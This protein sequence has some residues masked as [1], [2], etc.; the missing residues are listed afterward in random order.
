MTELE[1]HRITEVK[2]MRVRSRYPRTIT[3]N[4][5][6][7]V[8]GDGPNSQIRVI[9]TDGGASGW[10]IS[11]TPDEKTPD[12]VG[13]LVSELF[14]PKIG[15]IAEEAVWLDFPLHDL[16]GVILDKPVYQ[17]LGVKGDTA[18]P[19]YDGAI[20]MDDLIPEYAPRGIKAIIENC[21]NDYSMGYRA[22]K[23]KIGRGHKWM[24]FEEGLKRDIEVTRAVRENFSDCQILVDANDGYD[25]DGFLRY[26]DAVADC[27][28]FWI[29]EPFRENRDDLSRLRE[30]L[31][32][33]S[34]KTLVADG[35]SGPDV[36]FL[37]EL[38]REKLVDVL[39]MDIAG[40]GFT[41]WRHL[42]PRVI[43][44]GVCTSPHTWGDPLK[45]HYTT[46]IAAGLGNV[47]TVEGI[48]GTTEHV[49]RSL[50]TLEE[51]FL[52]VPDELG[53]GMRLIY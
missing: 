13:K 29:E 11:W 32:K 35:E 52:H 25:C 5:R 17:M 51:G 38:S 27:E 30:L 15:V 33:Q 3:R 21:R 2:T 45:T 49:D 16:A 19:C 42:M 46:Q 40:Y 6:I 48:P 7:G 10:G 36:E 37:L 53:F 9:T 8:H 28:I 34:P 4:S 14:D 31:E 24:E 20:Y 44:T 18:V 50:Y 1:K 12:V 22:F 26:F 41:A 39:L 43:E 47:V 23:L